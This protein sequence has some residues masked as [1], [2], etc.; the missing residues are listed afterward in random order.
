MHTARAI[1]GSS[2]GDFRRTHASDGITAG[3]VCHGSAC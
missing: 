3:K 1:P 2:H